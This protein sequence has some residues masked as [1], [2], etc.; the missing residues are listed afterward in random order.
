MSLGDVN[1]ELRLKEAKYML[2]YNLNQDNYVR[3]EVLAVVT[4][5]ITVP[6]MTPLYQ[7]TCHHS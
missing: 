4:I 3:F 2:E 6:R 1:P 7:T 5:Q